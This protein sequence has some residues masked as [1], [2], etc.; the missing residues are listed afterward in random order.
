MDNNVETQIG[1]EIDNLLTQYD[2]NNQNIKGD[3]CPIFFSQMK[4]KFFT[5]S[6][7]GKKKVRQYLFNKITTEKQKL[8]PDDQRIE[9][10]DYFLNKMCQCTNTCKDTLEESNFI[11]KPS[12]SIFSF[13]SSNKGGKRKRKGIKTNKKSKGQKK[14]NIKRRTKRRK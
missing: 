5:L 10:L 8:Q 4:N 7:D 3:G 9:K 1:R 6:N 2:N 13:L 12:T 11:N 14:R